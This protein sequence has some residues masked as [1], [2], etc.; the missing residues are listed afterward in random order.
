M[1]G[2][3]GV[4]KTREDAKSSLFGGHEDHFHGVLDQSKNEGRVVRG[5]ICKGDAGVGDGMAGR[6]LGAEQLGKGVH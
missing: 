3:R 5:D 2:G 1:C 6:I 4:K